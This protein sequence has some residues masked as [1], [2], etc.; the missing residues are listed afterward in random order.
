MRVPVIVAFVCIGI[1]VHAEDASKIVDRYIKAA[2]GAKAISSIQT[3]AIEGTMAG[4][5]TF[6]FDTKLPNSYYSELVAGDKSW[7]EAY[8][9]KSAWRENGAGEVATFLGEESSQ[10]EATGQYYNV[11]LLN[12]K[13]NKLVLSFIGRAQVHGN[14]TLQIE[15]TA[16]NGIKR[17]V[18]FDAVTHLIVE[19]KAAIGGVEIAMMYGDYRSV[20]S[21]KIPYAIELQR[22]KD[23]YR[24]QVTRAEINGAIAPHVFDFPG[25]SQVQLPDLQAL[26]KKIDE[27]QKTIRKIT[28]NYTAAPKN[29]Q[30]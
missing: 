5:G 28:E 14:D 22:G 6:T 21:V 12:L 13:R 4:V 9:G 10:L 16:A 27:N 24:I 3:L 19:E 29:R 15:V 1:S 20:A 17:E 23:T 30:S 18:Y 26:F 25:K 7:I 2:G 8:N 11:R